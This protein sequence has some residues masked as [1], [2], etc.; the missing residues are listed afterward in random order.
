M[1]KGRWYLEGILLPRAWGPWGYDLPTAPGPLGGLDGGEHMTPVRCGHPAA[2]AQGG[3]VLRGSCS[4]PT[5][6]RFQ[7]PTEPRCSQHWALMGAV[8]GPRP[9]HT[10]LVPGLCPGPGG[11]SGARPRR[12]GRRGLLQ[13]PECRGNARPGVRSSAQPP[14]R[15]SR[16]QQ[17]TMRPCLRHRVLLPLEEGPHVNSPTAGDQSSANEIK[18]S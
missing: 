18:G 6:P 16:G 17:D 4:P 15:G 7:T 5:W 9:C 10:A 13:S 8:T 3:P 11:P 12:K 1:G 14:P 2:Q